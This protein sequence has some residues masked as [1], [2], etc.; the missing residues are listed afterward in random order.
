MTPRPGQWAYFRLS[1]DRRR[2]MAWVEGECGSVELLD[3]GTGQSRDL[4]TFADR[5]GSCLPYQVA[6]DETLSVLA[7]GRPDGTL[8]VGRLEG[9][10]AH[11]LT[12]HQGPISDLAISPDGRW[13]ASITLAIV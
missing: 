7:V 6:V 12:G 11:L 8:L 13:V 5:L 4:R 10:S 1:G 2:L 9:D 3:L